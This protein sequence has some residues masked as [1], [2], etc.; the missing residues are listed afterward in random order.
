MLA[1][2]PPV[3]QV[4]AEAEEAEVES[5]RQ[6]H[7]ALQE[8]VAAAYTLMEQ[9]NLEEITAEEYEDRAPFA[10]EACREALARQQQAIAP[11]GKYEQDYMRLVIE[12]YALKASQVHCLEE[13]HRAI[14]QLEKGDI[15]AYRATDS[16]AR[17]AGRLLQDGA[18]L[19]EETATTGDAVIWAQAL[20]ALE[21]FRPEGWEDKCVALLKH[22][23]E[24][25]RYKVLH[26]LPTPVSARVKQLLPQLLKDPE[27]AMRY[28]ACYAARKAGDK[29]LL[30]DV[31]ALLKRE[32]RDDVIERAVGAAKRL[33]GGE[34]CADICADRLDDKRVADE[35][36][37]HLARWVV[38]SD[39]TGGR[40]QPAFKNQ[41]Q[42]AKYKAGW[43]AWLAKYGQQ[44]QDEGGFAPG[45]AR[46]D[47]DLFP[48]SMNR[49]TKDGKKWP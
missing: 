24:L 18:Q 11:L 12:S 32:T 36:M 38:R 2:S 35:M 42:A 5:A 15:E 20:G 45:D 30:P 34:A 49:R 44:V 39:S 25:V 7:R 1:S 33:G 23:V 3:G 17:A 13:L 46:L 29:A 6:V 43:K 41:Q 4:M 19:P 48:K 31:L 37:R 9:W 16:L 40:A 28:A 26:N 8:E 21:D 22:P 14:L 47:R 10:L 27:T